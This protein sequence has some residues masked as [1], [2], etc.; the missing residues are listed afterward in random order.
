MTQGLYSQ[1]FIFFVTYEWTQHE[2]VFVP[3]KTFQHGV[4][5]Q[6][7]LLDPFVHNEE[8]EVL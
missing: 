3:W 6:S 4:M 7:S 5:K 8:I 2:S 1:Y